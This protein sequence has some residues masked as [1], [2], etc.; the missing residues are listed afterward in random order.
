MKKIIHPF[1]TLAGAGPGDPDLITAGAIRALSE[2]D[3]VLYDALVHPS[4]LSYVSSR[5]V[6]LYVGKRKG[7][8]SFT[9]DEI[10]QLIVEHAFRFGHVVRLKGGDPFVFGRG[11]E[12]VEHARLFGI[13]TKVIPGVSSALAVPA[14]AGIP[15]THRGWSESFWVITATNRKGELSPDIRKAAQSN[16]TVVILM[17][18]HQLDEILK[19]FKQAGK[20]GLPVAIIQNGTLESERV[21][22]GT[23][24]SI[25]REARQQGIA[26]P[27]VIVAGEVARLH[28]LLSVLKRN[29]KTIMNYN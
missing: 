25:A 4:L 20:S 17:G 15:V 9:Q 11:Y 19:E 5:A 14:S 1:L 28:P 18:V 26:S 21:A 12:E 10:N 8:H 7:R 6:K 29:K 27:A 22:I 13:G 2:A 3:A 16:A 24:S 23:V